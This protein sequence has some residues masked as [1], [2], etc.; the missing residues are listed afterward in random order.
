MFRTWKLD[1]TIFLNLQVR[2]LAGTGFLN[3]EVNQTELPKK[4]QT[5]STEQFLNFYF[6]TF[7][8]SVGFV[9]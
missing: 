7:F 3:R 4:F 5:K 1:Q 6:T 9:G 8:K 2:L